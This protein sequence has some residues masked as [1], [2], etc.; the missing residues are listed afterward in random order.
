ME[1]IAKRVEAN[2]Q[3]FEE[4]FAKKKSSQDN[5]YKTKQ[6]MSESTP[7]GNKNSKGS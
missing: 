5:Y 1:E 7:T 4:K 2:R 3:A 6:V